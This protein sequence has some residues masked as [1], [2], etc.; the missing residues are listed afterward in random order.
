[1]TRFQK[2]GEHIDYEIAQQPIY[3]V[4][5]SGEAL[6]ATA[7]ELKVFCAK[8]VPYTCVQ[9]LDRSLTRK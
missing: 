2:V 3:A 9:N 8:T 4:R 5:T 7:E 6:N 1:M